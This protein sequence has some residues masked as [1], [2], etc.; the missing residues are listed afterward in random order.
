MLHFLNVNVLRK[1]YDIHL[2]FGALYFLYIFLGIRTRG[3]MFYGH[4]GTL[5]AIIVVEMKKTFYMVYR[6]I[7][8][9]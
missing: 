7:M 2:S 4:P 5:L 6:I 3:Q 1:I 8:N 9:E